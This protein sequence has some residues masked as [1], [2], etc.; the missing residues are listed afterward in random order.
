MAERRQR[1][2]KEGIAGFLDTRRV[3]PIQN[4]RRE[5]LWLWQAVLPL[6]RGHGL[7]AYDAAYLELANREGMH[8]ATLDHD[9]REAGRTAGVSILEVS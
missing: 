4:E 5:A 3:L 9:L 1:I 2:T 6:A 8:L 7:S